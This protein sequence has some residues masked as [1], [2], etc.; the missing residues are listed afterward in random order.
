MIIFH[1]SLNVTRLLSVASVCVITGTHQSECHRTDCHR[2]VICQCECH[3]SE[4]HQPEWHQ[5]KCHQ[6]SLCVTS[7]SVNCQHIF[8]MV[9]QVIVHLS[10][11]PSIRETKQHLH[12]QYLYL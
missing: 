10:F 3:Q 6:S 5:S 7:L 12:L 2:A 9:Y 11:C 4:F 8:L 1:I